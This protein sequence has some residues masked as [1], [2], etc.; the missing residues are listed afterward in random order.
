[1]GRLSGL[2]EARGICA[3]R[4][5]H[6]MGWADG[7][8][9]IERLCISLPYVETFNSK[10]I[11]GFVSELRSPKCLS[12][13]GIPMIYEYMLWA[14]YVRFTYPCLGMFLGYLPEIARLE[15]ELAYNDSAVHRFNHYTTR[16]HLIYREKYHVYITC[17]CVCVCV[18]EC[19]CCC[20]LN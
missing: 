7:K 4:A 15:Y 12:C 10:V 14:F 3:L 13:F 5:P 19:C 11:K 2:A 18:C 16:I 6:V 8:V 9:V 20:S 17:V 1:M